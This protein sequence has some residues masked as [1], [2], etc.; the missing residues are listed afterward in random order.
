MCGFFPFFSNASFYRLYLLNKQLSWGQCELSRL[1]QAWA[2]RGQVKGQR[3][4]WLGP[5]GL[6]MPHLR[7]AQAQEP[8]LSHL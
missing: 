7:A 4:R 1:Q 2:E 5:V 6:Q 8:E 3:G